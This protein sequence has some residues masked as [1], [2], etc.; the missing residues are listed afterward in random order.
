MSQLRYRRSLQ[1]QKRT[2][3]T[4]KNEI[5]KLFSMFVGDFCPPGS[6]YGSRDPNESGSNPDDT[7]SDPQ[8]CRKRLFLCKVKKLILARGYLASVVDEIADDTG[9]AY[10]VH[11]T[12]P[13]IRLL[14]EKNK[15]RKK[16][17][18][19]DFIICTGEVYLCCSQY[20]LEFVHY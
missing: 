8:H 11:Q 1:P 14:L 17:W 20:Q 10:G 6:G 15:E 16:E 9:N 5:Y 18:K 13:T 3:S 7:D 4:S 2:S 19:D 12:C